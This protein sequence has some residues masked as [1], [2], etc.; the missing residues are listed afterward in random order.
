MS[1]LSPLQMG[2]VGGEH[3]P[4]RPINLKTANLDALFVTISKDG[5]SQGVTLRD[6]IDAIQDAIIDA[7]IKEA[8]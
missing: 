8:T 1:S 7:I 5:R 2:V 3:A 6:L 4:S